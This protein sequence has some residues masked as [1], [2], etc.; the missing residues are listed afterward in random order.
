MSTTTFNSSNTAGTS[1][2]IA[3]STSLQLGLPS[4]LNGSAFSN[5]VE[6]G[7]GNSETVGVR[8]IKYT[9]SNDT[10][11]SST[12]ESGLG[13]LKDSLASED[14]IA[15]SAPFRFAAYS[16]GLLFNRH[17]K[18][19]D[20]LRLKAVYNHITDEFVDNF[21]KSSVF[22]DEFDGILIITFYNCSYTYA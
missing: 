19:V 20:L 12:S 22:D 10:V 17:P 1:S 13:V 16:R 8:D 21:I 6:M 7:R 18:R 15:N 11:Q 14:N 4:K 2:T 3:T 5:E 9:C